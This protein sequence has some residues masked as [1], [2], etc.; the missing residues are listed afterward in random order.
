MVQANANG[1]SLAQLALDITGYA[2]DA[3][4]LGNLGNITCG[5][6]IDVTPL[7]NCLE[8]RLRSNVVA[9]ANY[10]NKRANFGWPPGLY[11][12]S[13]KGINAIFGIGQMPNTTPDLDCEQMATV[14]TARGVIATIDPNPGDNTYT[15]MGF[16]MLDFGVDKQAGNGPYFT[17]YAPAVPRAALQKGDRVTFWN[18]VNYKALHGTK[19]GWAT[20]VVIPTGPDSYWG[21]N[22]GGGVTGNYAYWKQALRDGFNDGLPTTQWIGLQNVPGYDQGNAP[23]Q[24]VT[25]GFVNVPKLALALFNFRTDQG[26]YAGGGE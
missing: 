26:Q 21:Y 9:A 10:A 15:K 25:A 14:I 24:A 6:Q 4:A 12:F 17:Q 16:C 19:G 18:N 2:S 11:S 23:S 8:Q 3:S 5:E 7:L 13:E 22:G 20:E 1:A